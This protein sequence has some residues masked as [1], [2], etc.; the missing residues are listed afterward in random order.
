MTDFETFPLQLLNATHDAALF[1]VPGRGPTW[2]P[3]V[4]LHEDDRGDLIRENR[5][6]RFTVRID[7][8]TAKQKGLTPGRV[9]GGASGDLFEGQAP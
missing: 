1:S 5:G 6:Q 2:V 9:D 3:L 8:A 4:A 7:A